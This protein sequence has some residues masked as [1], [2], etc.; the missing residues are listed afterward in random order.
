MHRAHEQADQEIA[1]AAGDPRANQRTGFVIEQWP[2]HQNDGRASA[3]TE[4]IPRAETSGRVCVDS[5][6]GARGLS[7]LARDGDA[8][9]QA[10]RDRDGA[11]VHHQ[12]RAL[13]DY[14]DQVEV[15]AA[16]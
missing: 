1:P 15:R 14:L 12:V 16:E 7:R 11:S 6:A 10:A 3:A 9:E 4:W 2:R 13:A 8:L 5:G